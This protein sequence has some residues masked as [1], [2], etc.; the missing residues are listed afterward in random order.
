MKKLTLVVYTPEGKKFEENCDMVQI[1]GEKYFLGILPGH[2]SLVSDVII[3]KLTISND[4]A[5]TFCA[6]G[7]GVVSVEKDVVKLLVDSFEKGEEIDIER[8]I[9]SQ[10]RAEE[11][12]KNLSDEIDVVRAKASLTRA[13]NRISVANQKL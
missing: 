6:V 8:A 7:E 10:K 9:A 3:S 2:T 13:L 11:R 1:H 12:L 4:G 5:T